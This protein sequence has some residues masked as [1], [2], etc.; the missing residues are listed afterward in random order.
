VERQ[1]APDGGMPSFARLL[2]RAQIDAIAKHV[3]RM[4]HDDNPAGSWTVDIVVR[5]HTP[6]CR[7]ECRA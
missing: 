7:V 2:S 5:A 6:I 4:E 1:V 3:V